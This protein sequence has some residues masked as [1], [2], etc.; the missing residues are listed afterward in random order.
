VGVRVVSLASGSSGNAFLV[1]AGDTVILIDAGLSMRRLSYALSQLGLN[2]R[3]V[4]AVLLTH[5]HSDH[6][7][8]L[9]ML[10]WRCGL[11]V[12]GNEATLAAVGPDRHRARVLPTGGALEIG[13]VRVRSFALPHD[14]CEPV[15]YC[16]EHEGVR[17]CLA[18]DLGYAPE[19]LK[20][21]VRDSDLVI[22]EAN[23]DL[24][25]LI[26]GPYPQR[27]K[28]RIT[29]RVGHLSNEQTADGATDSEG[30]LAAGWHQNHGR[31]RGPAGQRQPD[32]AVGPAG[33]AGLAA[34]AW[35]ASYPAGASASARSTLPP[36]PSTRTL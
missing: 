33:L 12:V 25:R 11:P 23:H 18:T 15:G 35:D 21:H 29:S 13:S 2:L 19:T 22:L 36:L 32:M 6:T 5:E 7:R 30:P 26:R 4:Q 31:A 1:E 20:E 9:E 3:E 16:L 24:D 14:G 27:L 28:Q 10:S 8:G 17:V 34:L